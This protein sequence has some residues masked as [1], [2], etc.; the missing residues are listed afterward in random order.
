MALS[1]VFDALLSQRPY[2]QAW[3]QEEAV[4]AIDEDTGTAFE[5]RLVDCFHDALPEI[6][7]IIQKLA[8]HM[9]SNSHAAAYELGM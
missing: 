1:D 8:S 9:P 6:E 2:K 3:P 7:A 5:P 4:K